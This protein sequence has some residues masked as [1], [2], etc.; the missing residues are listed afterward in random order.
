M[1]KRQ[2]LGETVTVSA[3]PSPAEL[4]GHTAKRAT[5][6]NQTNLLPAEFTERYR[7]QFVDRLWLRG[8]AYAGLAYAVFLA[9]YF[10]A[11]A[12]RTYQATKVEGQVAAISN[13]YTNV[14][15][16]QA[17]YAVLQKRE[18]LKFAGLDCWQVVAQLLPSGI[19]LQR[20]SLTAGQKLALS[21]STTPDMV[22]TLFDFDS[23]MR[24]YKVKD[25]QG[26]EQQFFDP[27]QGE[28]V[29][30]RTAANITTWSCS[31]ILMHAEEEQP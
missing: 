18:Q 10:S 29:N 15:E 26:N 7:Q 6:A 25:A 4:A 13:E 20:M 2:A 31:L 16:L 22:N 28:H 5:T 27:Q 1:Y 12:F 23:A 19:Q 21:G 30:P 11:V 17:R 3:P 14:V 8:L 9:F 24:K